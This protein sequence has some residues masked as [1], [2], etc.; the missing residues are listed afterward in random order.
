MASKH[1]NKKHITPLIKIREEL[2]NQSLHFV[3]KIRIIPD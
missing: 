2:E 1:W 3:V